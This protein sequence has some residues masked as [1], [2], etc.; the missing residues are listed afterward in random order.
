MPALLCRTQVKQLQ[1][2]DLSQVDFVGRSLGQLR[3]EVRPWQ[4]RQ[5]SL[6]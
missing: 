1:A 4:P 3:Q 5:P 6:H 2:L